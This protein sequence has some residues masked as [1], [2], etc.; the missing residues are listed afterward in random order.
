MKGS[1]TCDH[2]AFGGAAILQSAPKPPTEGSTVVYDNPYTY[3]DIRNL[4][5]TD[6]AAPF[7]PTFLTSVA[8]AADL[9]LLAVLEED[10]I[11]ESFEVEIDNA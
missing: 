4:A 7:P 3:D 11:I 1:W 9:E 10:L 8:A 2:K 5:V 6:V